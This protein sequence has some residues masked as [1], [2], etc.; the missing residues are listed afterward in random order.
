MREAE[1]LTAYEDL[2][3]ALPD[4]EVDRL[5]RLL[6]KES[7]EVPRADP[8]TLS[9]TDKVAAILYLVQRY[10]KLR[11]HLAISD[12]ID[13]YDAIEGIDIGGIVRAVGEA[14]F[15]TPEQS[16][17]PPPP[18]T[19][20][21]VEQAGPPTWVWYALLGFFALMLIVVLIAV[22]RG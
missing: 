1:L 8:N 2:V 17:P 20:I 4:E 7:G 9:K 12:H 16:S 6:V 18:Q 13:T 14:I 15:G 21:T 19:N 3:S 22:A 11:R 10:P 5:L